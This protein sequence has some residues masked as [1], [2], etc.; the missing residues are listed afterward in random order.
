M[1][2][3]LI[4]CLIV[5]TACQSRAPKPDV[6][7]VPPPQPGARP[8]PPTA[9]APVVPTPAATTHKVALILG[10]GGAK[11]FAHVG[12]LKALQRQRVPIDKVIGLEWG[13]L[14]GGVFAH[15]G[16]VHDLEWKLYKME[17]QGLPHAPKSGLFGRGG[18]VAGV[19]VMNGF[20][21]ETFGG[22]DAGQTRVAFACPTRSMWTGVVTWQT[23]G[24]LREVTK[25]C[26]PYPP[27]FNIEGSVVAGAT[28]VADA[29]DVLKKEGFDVIVFVNVLGSAIPAKQEGLP[30]NATTVIL[31]QE[32]K[33]EIARA[34]AEVETIEVNTN[35]HPIT[36]FEASKDL[37]Q[38]GETTGAAAAQ[39]LIRKFGF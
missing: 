36:Q 14:I 2:N 10:P 24:P 35:A 19:N 29:I 34:G 12:V 15:H 9:S 38:L 18:G 26:L 5:L 16:Q 22:D 7:K 21:N 27:V 13:A 17:Q 32:V 39:R 30:D 37:V 4:L 31:W 8:A 28:Q 6:T 25:R 3:L 1:S 33:R 20:L 11:A 23:R